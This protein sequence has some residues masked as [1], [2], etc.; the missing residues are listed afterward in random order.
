MTGLFQGIAAI[1]ELFT[2][3]GSAV[4][5]VVSFVCVASLFVVDWTQWVILKVGAILNPPL[6]EVCGCAKEVVKEVGNVLRSVS[7]F[8]QFLP[9]LV[10][11]LIIL[12]LAMITQ[13]VFRFATL[14]VNS[15]YLTF[16]NTPQ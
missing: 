15:P 11:I 12:G 14:K 1:V 2:A 7:K 16:D 5:A 13:V 3:L 10:T 9:P 6:S 8:L 4:R